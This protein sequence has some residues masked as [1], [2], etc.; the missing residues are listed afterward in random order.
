MGTTGR[1]AVIP[2]D[3]PLAI[4]TKHLAAI[5]LNRKLAHPEFIAYAIH[6]HP[7]IHHQ[8]ERA[9]RGAIMNGLNLTLI[10]ELRFRVPPLPIQEHFAAIVQKFRKI[11]DKLSKANEYGAG[12]L[13]NSL[14]KRAFRGELVTSEAELARREGRPYEP[15]SI[16]LDKIEAQKVN[17]KLRG[18]HKRQK[19]K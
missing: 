3:I 19:G 13:F 2:D 4:T 9:Q 16:L 14:V 7:E 17:V 1:S 8:I 12:D 6:D 5:T 11:R 10:K 18:K 15:T